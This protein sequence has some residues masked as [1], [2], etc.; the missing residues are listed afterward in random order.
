MKLPNIWI[1]ENGVLL[2]KRL[3]QFL[4]N[5]GKKTGKGPRGRFT[6]AKFSIAAIAVGNFAWFKYLNVSRITVLTWGSFR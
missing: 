6:G 3:S 4:S 1:A 5:S 2:K